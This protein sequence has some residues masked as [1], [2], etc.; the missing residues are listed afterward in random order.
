MG[1][2]LGAFAFCRQIK[3]NQPPSSG[4]LAW[5]KN[6]IYSCFDFDTTYWIFAHSI[7][8]KLRKSLMILNFFLTMII[9]FNINF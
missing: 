5:S 8:F 4:A 1:V 9:K 3:S 7:R 6:V 2:S